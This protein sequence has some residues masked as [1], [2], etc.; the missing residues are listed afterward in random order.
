MSTPTR[1]E[2]VQHATV[3][4]KAAFT[5]IQWNATQLG[6]ALP[7]DANLDTCYEVHFYLALGNIHVMSDLYHSIVEA[8]SHARSIS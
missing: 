3:L 8:T 1:F 4:A 2:L 6:S 5:T 7:H